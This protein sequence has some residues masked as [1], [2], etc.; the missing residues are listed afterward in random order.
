MVKATSGEELYGWG[1][2]L[3]QD[4]ITNETLPVLAYVAEPGCKSLSNWD[5]SPIPFAFSLS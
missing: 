2:C 5:F 4:R 3:F 1:S